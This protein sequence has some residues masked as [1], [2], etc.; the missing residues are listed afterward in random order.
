MV[1]DE[2]LKSPQINEALQE[3]G[4]TEEQLYDLKTW[5]DE[6]YTVAELGLDGEGLERAWALQRLLAAK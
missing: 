5:L 6:G 3:L 2:G 1:K 4:A